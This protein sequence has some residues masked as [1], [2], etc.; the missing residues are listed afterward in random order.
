MV[1]IVHIASPTIYKSSCV[2]GSPFVSGL[3]LM[4][5]PFKVKYLM[6]RPFHKK[7]IIEETIEP[8]VY[9]FLCCKIFTVFMLH[10]I[11]P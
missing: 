5:R 3:R 7:G 6:H 1:S 4:H 2:A 9:A 11:Y 8:Y 10:D